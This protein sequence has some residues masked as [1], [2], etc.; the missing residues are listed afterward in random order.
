M[1]TTARLL[2]CFRDW[3]STTIVWELPQITTRE[4]VL[5][6]INI[7]KLRFHDDVGLGKN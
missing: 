2:M 5:S 3:L 4:Q 7:N 1:G 6:S